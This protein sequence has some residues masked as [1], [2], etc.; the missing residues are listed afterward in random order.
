M[1]VTMVKAMVVFSLIICTA[2]EVKVVYSR[3]LIMELVTTTVGIMKMQESTVMV[4]IVKHF[5][6]L[7]YYI[8]RQDNTFIMY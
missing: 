4:K 1:L 7:K 5:I 2:M 8:Y 6:T 3:V